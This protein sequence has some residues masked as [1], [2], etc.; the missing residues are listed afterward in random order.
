[1]PYLGSLKPAIVAGKPPAISK[2]HC[3]PENY[4]LS[5]QRRGIGPGSE[6][7]HLN[8]VGKEFSGLVNGLIQV[9]GAYGHNGRTCADLP[10][11]RL[12]DGRRIAKPDG[13]YLY[14]G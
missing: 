14:S 3:G 12:I 7:G 10:Q 13:I 9:I 1:R 5:C 2:I 4:I 11:G 6:K 8:F